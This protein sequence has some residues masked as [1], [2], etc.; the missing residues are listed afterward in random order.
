MTRTPP[1]ARTTDR[2]R[3]RRLPDVGLPVVLSVITAA[4]G[5]QVAKPPSSS[6]AS[7]SHAP[8]RGHLGAFGEAGGVVPDGVTVVDDAMW[9]VAQLLRAAVSAYELRT[10]AIERH[11]PRTYADPIQDPRPQQ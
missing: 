1:S 3:I 10:R 8:R 11:C 5:H 4:L 7:P 2:R 6:G 9:A